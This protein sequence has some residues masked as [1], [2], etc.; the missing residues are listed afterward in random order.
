MNILIIDTSDNNS[1]VALYT[2]A[3]QDVIRLDP[4]RKQS[5]SL[6]PTLIELLQKNNL[7]PTQLD[8]ISIGN[9]PGSF[10]GTR[11]GVMAAKTLA[12][13]SKCPLVSFCSLAKY[14]P[15]N[16]GTFVVVS[17]GKRHGYYT[18]QGIKAG[19]K[20]TFHSM[21]HLVPK[22]E[23]PEELHCITG[24]STIARLERATLDPSHLYHSATTA[25][26][27]KRFIDPMRLSINYL[28]TP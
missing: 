8:A 5:Q 27:R 17:D 1:F 11:I 3:T 12:Y 22:E 15:K 19:E 9:G 4:E 28:T 7:R 18:L 21:P 26:K 13:A 24:D 25:V 14:I 16:D 6:L 10:T 20:Y 2:P 23:L